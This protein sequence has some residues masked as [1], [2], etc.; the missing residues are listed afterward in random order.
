MEHPADRTLKAP[1]PLVLALR[2]APWVIFGPITGFFVDR[3]SRAVARGDWAV[4]ALLLCANVAAVG[5]LP[6][7]TMLIAGKL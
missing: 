2:I 3:A 5:S 4:A 1:Q 6:V 7:L